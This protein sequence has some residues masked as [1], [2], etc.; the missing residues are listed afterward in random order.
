MSVKSKF[1]AA[2]AGFAMVP[3]M[4][5]ALP[6]SDANAHGWITGP[7]SRQEQCKANTVSC[8]DI[9][10]EPQSVEGPKGLRNCHGNVGRF[11]ELNDDGKGWRATNVG[12]TV[13]FNWRLT[14]AHRTSTWEYY[15]GGTRVAVFN[16][17]GAQPPSNISHTVNLGN[18]SGRQKVL[19]IWNIFDTPMAFY[20]CV[21][22]NVG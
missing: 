6:S 15:I 19:A 12:R 17:N 11:A 7:A 13:T 9:K 5:V 14:A 2:A 4:M 22:L 10:W 20:N 3:G 21:D 8:G 1:L 16:D 18:Y